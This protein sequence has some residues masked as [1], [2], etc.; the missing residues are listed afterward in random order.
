[1]C[2]YDGT[3]IK[4]PTQQGTESSIEAWRLWVLHYSSLPF[5]SLSCR[6][7]NKPVTMSKEIPDFCEQIIKPQEGEL[8]WNTDFLASSEKIQYLWLVS[9]ET[10]P[11]NLWVWCNSRWL[12]SR[13]GL[14]CRTQVGLWRVNELV[15]VMEK[16]HIFGVR[17][18]MSKSSLHAKSQFHK[19]GD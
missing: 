10:E 14:N 11:W 19:S 7:Y 13:V 9:Y 2:V 1:M 6:L 4:T 8:L 3:S 18:I 5:S 12:V 16:Q 15:I 17:S